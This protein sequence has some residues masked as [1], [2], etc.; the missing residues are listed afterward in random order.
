M[1]ETSAIPE[2]CSAVTSMVFYSVEVA[3]NVN[4]IMV[5]STYNRHNYNIA[6]KSTCRT[7]YIK[8]LFFDYNRHSLSIINTPKEGN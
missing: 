1:F 3:G 2:G 7:K 4:I 6:N 8:L 5:H